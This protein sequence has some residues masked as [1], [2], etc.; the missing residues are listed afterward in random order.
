MGEA[1]QKR[2]TAIV[3]GDAELRGLSAF[4]GCL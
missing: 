2:R 4:L 3:E 1:Q